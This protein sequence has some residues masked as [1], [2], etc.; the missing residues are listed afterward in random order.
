[1]SVTAIPD[2]VRP[3]RAMAAATLGTSSAARSNSTMGGTSLRSGINRASSRASGFALINMGSAPSIVKPV[4][5]AASPMAPRC[6]L[7][8]VPIRLPIWFATY[9]SGV[10]SSSA[11]VA[12][13]KAQIVHAA[14]MR[15][16]DARVPSVASTP[17]LVVPTVAPMVTLAASFH[18]SAPPWRATMTSAIGAALDCIASPRSA[19]V[20]ARARRPR[21]VPPS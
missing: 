21:I 5:N 7:L 9:R 17:V 18:P 10:K 14:A 4:W 16:A 11:R 2:S 20:D 1:M 15:R 8:P 12:C 6:A 13:T 3:R 19:P